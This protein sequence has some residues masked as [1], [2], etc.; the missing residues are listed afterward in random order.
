M[1]QERLEQLR[2]MLAD[3]PGD[4]FLR[5]AIALELKRMGAMEQ[6]I[7]DLEGI[8]RDEP[9]HVASYYQL[10]VMLADLGRTHEA[11]EACDAG[12]LQCIIKGDRKARMELLALREQLSEDL[13]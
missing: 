5:Y 2:S 6:S 7:M 10:A 8:L 12:S 11:I 1:S 4:L 9:G 13:P 3:E